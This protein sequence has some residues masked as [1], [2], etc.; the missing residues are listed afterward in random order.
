MYYISMN[1]FLSSLPINKCIKW[2]CSFCYFFYQR[3]LLKEGE[4]TQHSMLGNVLSVLYYV[5][6]LPL[7]GTNWTKWMKECWSPLQAQHLG[8]FWQKCCVRYF[9]V[10]APPWQWRPDLDFI[11][12]NK[13]NETKLKYC[14]ILYYISCPVTKPCHS[15]KAA[16][17]SM[18]K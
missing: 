11:L 16:F 6:G 10:A 8:Y 7:C 9:R 15:L 3:Y 18:N 2:R 14:I 13:M 4:K 12:N 5:M 17:L 1:D